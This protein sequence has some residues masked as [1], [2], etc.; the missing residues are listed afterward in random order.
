M[1]EVRVCVCVDESSGLPGACGE[2]SVWCL[3]ES[4]GGESTCSVTACVSLAWF[5]HSTVDE[6]MVTSD[7]AM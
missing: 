2:R 5:C 4:S 6:L 7:V 1:G 3:Y